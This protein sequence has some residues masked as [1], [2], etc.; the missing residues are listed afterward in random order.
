MSRH[1]IRT[2][3]RLPDSLMREI[4]RVAAESDLTIAA[5]IENAI[6]QALARHG[7]PAKRRA[8]K[9]P[10]AGRGGLQPGVDLDDSAL[11]D[12]MEGVR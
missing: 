6:R 12:L 8:I 4:R 11:L 1:M 5:V 10:T 7:T 9:L 3:I 2:T